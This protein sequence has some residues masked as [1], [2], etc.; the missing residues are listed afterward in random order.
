M[1]SGYSWWHFQTV[2]IKLGWT[3]VP[4]HSRDFLTFQNELDEK[5]VIIKENNMNLDYLNKLLRH[6]GISPLLFARLA[7]EPTK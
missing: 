1:S 7:T 2:L 6:L 3:Q 5:M 4:N